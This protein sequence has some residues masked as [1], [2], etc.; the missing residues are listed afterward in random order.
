[1]CG[2]GSK[3]VMKGSVLRRNGLNSFTNHRYVCGDRMWEYVRFLYASNF[4]KKFCYNFFLQ[5]QLQFLLRYL[6]S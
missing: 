1:M 5:L 3:S 6:Q 4:Y 2:I